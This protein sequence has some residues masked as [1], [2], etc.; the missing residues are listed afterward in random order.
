[1]SKETLSFVTPPPKNYKIS[2]AF[3]YNFKLA[4]TFPEEAEDYI[5]AVEEYEREEEQRMEEHYAALRSYVKS[6]SK[7]ELQE[8]LFEAL[9]ELEE[10]GRYY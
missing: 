6:L 7:K 9:V 2:S 8:K 3:S 4:L 10:R 1:M 5:E